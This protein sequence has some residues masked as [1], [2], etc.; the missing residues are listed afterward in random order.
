M[1]E[2]KPPT[3]SGRSEDFQGDIQR[4][5]EAV[6]HL[7]EAAVQPV[8]RTLNVLGDNI[9]DRQDAPRVRLTSL[10]NAGTSLVS[11]SIR[12]AERLSSLAL[13]I[14]TPRGSAQPNTAAAT[15][16]SGRVGEALRIPMAVENPG[17]EPMQDLDFQVV[18]LTGPEG[19]SLS[20][21]SLSISPRTLSVA[22][23]DFEK[24]VLHVDIP[25]GAVA[26]LYEGRLGLD[27]K[28]HFEV[29]F[30]FTVV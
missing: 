6:T 28:S 18:A 26:G 20:G 1:S 30:R 8:V 22:P 7:A 25:E 2:T 21:A 3:D 16:P 13:D 23:G 19:S 12:L 5:V 15:A 24:L 4:L 27:G 9:G 10:D 11:S 29:P 14:V 17:R